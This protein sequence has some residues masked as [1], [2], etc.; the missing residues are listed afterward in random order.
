MAPVSL[1]CCDAVTALTAAV[2]RI[3]PA[4]AV[5]TAV[6]VLIPRR[7]DT[8]RPRVVPA[9][10]HAPPRPPLHREHQTVITGRAAA[11]CPADKTIARSTAGWIRQSEP[12]AL[13]P[14]ARR[15]ARGEADSV[16]CAGS[17]PQEHR[18]IDLLQT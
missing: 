12:S 15:R 7:S 6:V 14:V 10:G 18:R 4:R 5:Q 11:V 1:R 2:V 17:Q 8:V 13:I 3:L 16:Q 9:H